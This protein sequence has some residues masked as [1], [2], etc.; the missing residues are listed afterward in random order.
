M[1]ITSTVVRCCIVPNT[2]GTAFREACC[3]EPGDQALLGTHSITSPRGGPV[4]Q[5]NEPR[6]ERLLFDMCRKYRSREKDDGEKDSL[7]QVQTGVQST[8]PLSG[9]GLWEGYGE[10]GRQTAGVETWKHPALRQQLWDG[11][12]ARP[13]QHMQFALLTSTQLPRATKSTLTKL[14]IVISFNLRTYGPCA[15]DGVC[16]YATSIR[17]LMKGP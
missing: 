1:V 4:M 2:R 7:S 17:S 11:K 12:I 16:S 9:C 10:R 14:E 15:S 8:L 3:K 6:D 13:R 5:G